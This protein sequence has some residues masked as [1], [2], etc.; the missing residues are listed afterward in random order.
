MLINQFLNYTC[1]KSDVV[2]VGKFLKL[3]KLLKF[4]KKAK[5]ARSI[6][7]VKG[8]V[9]KSDMGKIRGS[10]SPKRPRDL[11]IAMKGHNRFNADLAEAKAILKR[12]EK[13]GADQASI[14]VAK[15]NISLIKAG[16]DAAIQRLRNL[17]KSYGIS[18][19]DINKK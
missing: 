16:R 10:S 9:N 19:R 5:K 14:E 15:Q 13:S 12:L 17:Y 3:G 4:G 6:D 18:P 7:N 1:G 8:A 2:P 11:T